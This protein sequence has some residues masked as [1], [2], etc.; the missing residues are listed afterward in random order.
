[1]SNKYEAEAY[2]LNKFDSYKEYIT[3]LVKKLEIQF[4]NKM[5]DLESK[6][7]SVRENHLT[8]IICLEKDFEIN[9]T[10]KSFASQKWCHHYFIGKC[11]SCH[12]STIFSHYPSVADICSNCQM[13]NYTVV[14]LNK[15]SKNHE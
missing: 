3:S 8:R 7:D 6:V 1:M 11:T 15:G 2:I 14:H 9:T 4:T 5:N 13:N 10:N 12:Y